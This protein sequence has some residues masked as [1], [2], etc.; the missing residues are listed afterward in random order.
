MANHDH[1]AH[2]YDNHNQGKQSEKK[3]IEIEVVPLAD[4][5]ADPGA[6]MIHA[7]HTNSTI[8]AV[9]SPAG[10]IDIAGGT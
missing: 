5:C 2:D 7:F 1:Y 6:V 3:E 10:S 8:A 4:A 9:T